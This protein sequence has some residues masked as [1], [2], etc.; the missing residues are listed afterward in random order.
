MKSTERKLRNIIRN[1]I[2]ENETS[3]NV[4]AEE[5]RGVLSALINLGVSG[6]S[7]LKEESFGGA[8]TNVVKATSLS[9][10]AWAAVSILLSIAA[11]S[12]M[13]FSSITPEAISAYVNQPALYHLMMACISGTLG[14]QT[15][16]LT[17]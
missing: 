7:E 17:K 9:A 11:A 14:A 8:I 3:N 12:G 16:I 15:H 4:N 5:V 10:N 1:V 13:D 6:V 2:L